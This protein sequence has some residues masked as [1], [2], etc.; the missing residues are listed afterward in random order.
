MKRVAEPLNIPVRKTAVR[1]EH[2]V[3][4]IGF[5]KVEGKIGQEPEPLGLPIQT[6]RVALDLSPANPLYIIHIVMEMMGRPRVRKPATFRAIGPVAVF[7]V[8][9]ILR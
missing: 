6:D 7:R 3:R 1:G 4:V 8:T 9:T 2:E 5:R